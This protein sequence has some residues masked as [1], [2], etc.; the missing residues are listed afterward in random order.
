M[1]SASLLRRRV[2]IDRVRPEVDCGRFAVKRIVGEPVWIEAD[3]ICDGHEELECAVHVRHGEAGSWRTIPLECQGNDL[4]T[5][6]FTPDALGL[7]QFF[8]TARVDSF[9][10][11]LRDLH[12]RHDAGEDLRPEL[13][14]GSGMVAQAAHRAPPTAAAELEAIAAAIARSSSPAVASEPRVAE[15]M[16]LH[17]DRRDETR[18]DPPRAIRVERPLARSSA[19]YE[20]FPRSWGR[21]GAHGT[22]SDLADRIDYV[23]DMGFDVLYLTPLHPIGSS[24]RKGRNND[25]VASADDVGSPWAIGSPAGGHKAIHPQLGTFE[26][27]ERLRARATSL[28]MELAIDLAIQCSPDHPW[29]KEHP[30]WFRR[31]SDGSIA[32]AENPPKKYQDIVPFDFQCDAWKQLWEAL[33]DVV[34][35]WVEKGVRIFRVD[36]PHT[37][38][39][40]FW[41]WLIT[42][43]HRTHPDVI[44]LSEA[45]TRPKTMYRLAKLGFTQSYTYFT[46]RTEKP[47]TGDYLVEVSTPPISDFFRANFWPN[48]PDILHA[49]LQN[50]GR[51]MFLVRL[52]LAAL[53]A[54]NWGIYGPA[55][56]LMESTPVQPGSEEYLDSEKY[57]IKRW[58]LADPESLAPFITQLNAIRRAEPAIR[59]ARPV[60]IHPTDD[61]HVLAFSRFDAE[62]GSRLLV[63]V[64]LDP[65]SRS[66]ARVSIDAAALGLPPEGTIDAHEL[67]GGCTHRWPSGEAACECTPEQ[68]ALVYRLSA[69]S[70]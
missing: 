25:L 24:F 44:F 4:W 68:P 3:I 15:L 19:W 14:T 35:F 53:G 57:E 61:D 62:S 9:G 8:I 47:E 56:E 29:V 27:F 28:G 12:R 31:R 1:E 32:Y 17:A 33:A 52:A 26:D 45:F 48:T 21:G 59:L 42:G 43:I 58:N 34:R 2:V 20:V 66:T 11:W 41:E 70:G 7:W 37:K 60:A 49:T 30:E 40:A 22:L 55:M 13:L 39:F 16:Q 64:N 69:A 10:T 6:S 18:L 67:L 46:W 54:A 5:A 65:T 63:V 50:G 36:N 51:P 23:A 38:P